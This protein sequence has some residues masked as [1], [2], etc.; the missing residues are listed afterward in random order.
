MAANAS[1]G[2][3]VTL[4]Q[5][6]QGDVRGGVRLRKRAQAQ[7]SKPSV[8][9]AATRPRALPERWTSASIG[10]SAVSTV[11]KRSAMTRLHSSAARVSQ[12]SA[13]G[14]ARPRAVLQ[15]H[16]RLRRRLARE[17]HRHPAG[18][19][20]RLRRASRQPTGRQALEHGRDTR[21]AA[22]VVMTADHQLA[23]EPRRQSVVRVA[24]LSQ[25]ALD[26]VDGIHPPEQR[27]KRLGH[28]ERDVGALAR[29]RGQTQ[30]LLQVHA[31]A[32]HA[33]GRLRTRGLSKDA[34]RAAAGGGSASAR[35][36]NSAAPRGAPLCV[37]ARAP[38]R[39]RANTQDRPP[40]DT[41][42]MRGDP[43]RRRAIQFQNPRCRAVSR[44][45]LVAA[46][47]TF[48]GVAHNRMD[49]PWTIVRGQDLDA[50]EGC[51]EDYRVGHLQ[52][53]HRRGVAKLAAVPEHRECLGETQS[54]RTKP[55]HSSQHPP[56]DAL[57]ARL[58]DAPPDRP[59]PVT[60]HRF[61]PPAA[62]R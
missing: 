53:N 25:R 37:A 52:T 60:P 30:R 29:I 38:S 54:A 32:L 41:D 57:D 5:H 59:R 46:E 15:R 21:G 23:L 20:E 31:R 33:R 2:A 39:N 3:K 49:E 1:P 18:H 48:D 7:L 10:S 9:Y 43:T 24:E 40:G 42:E 36:S 28:L 45:P 17:N 19:R 55:T 58:A 12:F 44:V 56:R 8:L 4:L 16:G 6:L 47:R 22:G 11:A 14:D 61:R 62:A 26:H 34:T 13:C 51:R 50:D 27:G 35:S